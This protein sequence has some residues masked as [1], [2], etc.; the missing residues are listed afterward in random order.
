L[1][2]ES[3]VAELREQ[4]N[5]PPLIEAVEVP[6]PIGSSSSDAEDRERLEEE[7]DTVNEFNPFQS[8]KTEEPAPVAPPVAPPVPDTASVDVPWPDTHVSSTIPVPRPPSISPSDDELEIIRRKAHKAQPSV[9]DNT[10]ET[11]ISKIPINAPVINPDVR[12]QSINPRFIR[13]T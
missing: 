3:R 10:I 8:P 9:E 12:A 13:R 5:L 1:E 4:M 6:V 7:S 11:P 2:L